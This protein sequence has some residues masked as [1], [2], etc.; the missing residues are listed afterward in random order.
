MRANAHRLGAIAAALLFSLV[1]VNAGFGERIQHTVRP[2]ETLS[3]ISGAYGISVEILV[4]INEIADPNLII[5]GEV[6]NVGSHSTPAHDAAGNYVIQSGDTL[7]HIALHFDVTVDDLKAANGLD[8]DLI[9]A[10]DTLLIPGLVAAPPAPEPEF[11]MPTTPIEPPRE[12][13]Q[14]PEIEG[15]IDELAAAEGIEPGLVKSI[16][17]LESGWNQGAR[18]HAGAVG[19]MQLMPGTTAWLESDFFGQDLNDETS[20][21]DNIKLG[22]YYL[23]LLEYETGSQELAV[24]AYYQGLGVTQQGVMYNETRRYVD[25]V[26]AVK[27]RYWP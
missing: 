23:S 10:G 6:L 9:I 22:V 27:A 1:T 20:V 16:A 3:G 12:R 15:L 14:S 26:M 21:Y 7:S 18:S 24:A 2:G 5:V 13:P 4:E 11:V 8:S 25:G 17:W 19:I